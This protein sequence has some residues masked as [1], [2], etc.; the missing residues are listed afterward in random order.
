MG[1]YL[2]VSGRQFD[3]DAYLRRGSL[4]AARVYRRGEPEFKSKPRGR[5]LRRSGINILVS[6]RDQSD[7]AGQ[8]KDAVRFLGRY[9]RAIQALRRRP[10]VEGGVLDFGVEPRA[11]AAI[12]MNRFPAQLVRLAGRAELALELSTWLTS[13]QQLGR[14]RPRRRIRNVLPSSA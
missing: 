13:W 8:L 2:R 9:M 11:D 7:F 4:T 5:K 12:Q 3:V 14:A 1:C 6:L 10:G